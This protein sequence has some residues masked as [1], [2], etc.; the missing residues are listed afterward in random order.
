VANFVIGISLAISPDG[1]TFNG[2]QTVTI[3]GIP[4]G[5][6]CIYTTDGADP[7][8]GPLGDGYSYTG[9]FTVSKSETIKAAT[10]FSSV[11]SAIFVINGSQTVA[12][13]P[14]GGSFNAPQSVII[15]GIP[16][17]DTCSYTTNGSNPTTTSTAVTYSGAFTVS[18]SETVQAAIHD[19]VSGWG[20]VTAATFTIGGVPS[21][22]APIITP[23]G[24]TFT[25]PQSVTVT[26]IPDGDTCYYSTDGAAPRYGSCTP[27]IGPFTVSQSETVYVANQNQAGDWGDAASAIFT[28]NNQ[29]TVPPAGTLMPGE[30]TTVAGNNAWGYSG[31]NGPATSAWLDSPDGVAVDA[32]G[33]L[34][35]ADT[36]N[37]RIRKVDPSGTITTVAGDGTAGYSGDNGPAISAELDRPYGVAVDASG[38]L[39]IA[40]TYNQRIRK[41]ST[42]GTITTVAG[43]GHENYP[44]ALNGGGYSGDGG[45]ATDAELNAPLAVAV[46]TSGN[47]YIAD[48]YNQRIRKVDTSGTI[49]TVA[50]NGQGGSL[51]GYS[52]D[53]GPATSAE[54]AQ[55]TGVAVDA[56]GDIYIISDQ[57]HNCIRKVDTSG[58]I[59]TVAYDGLIQAYTGPPVLSTSSAALSLPAGVT[60]DA[61]G[62]L[63]YS[64]GYSCVRKIVHTMD[65]IAIVAGKV[66]TTGYSGDGGPAV[67]AELNCPDGVAVDSS[68]DIFIADTG[69]NRIREVK[70]SGSAAPTTVENEPIDF[71]VGQSSYTAAGQFFA[72]DVAPLIDNGRALVPVRYLADA[73]GAQTAWDAAARTITITRGRTTI[74]LAVGSMSI[75]SNGKSSQMDTAPLI[76]DGRTYLP[77]RYLAEAL[78]CNVSWNAAVQSVTVSAQPK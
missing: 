70:T 2:P 28:I 13:T 60:V 27:Y 12:I 64:D 4:S 11:V 78:G 16:S 32:S 75:T 23:D 1:G 65:N 56:S 25:A 7:I 61:S 55:P 38:N 63:Y 74:E 6:A 73:L 31:D 52:G 40:D 5:C 62:N 14:D 44:G 68:G 71:T 21:S 54:L 43:N 47:L 15:T 57:Y 33:N 22:Q 49:S 37:N 34:Y 72:M 48:T 29:V 36:S 58:T 20:G 30:I 41:V 3:T 66:D 46:D 42:S 17:G 35:I 18:Q 50:G 10:S 69:N 67:D 9:P 8:N 51:G 19:P 26:G 76:E 77:A 53:G 45:L 59:T 39:Y 24:G